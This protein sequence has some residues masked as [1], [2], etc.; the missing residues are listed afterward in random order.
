MKV[1]EVKSEYEEDGKTI[2]RYEHM[3]HFDDDIVALTVAVGESFKGYDYDLI[4][5]RE[6]L[7]IVRNF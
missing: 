2:T 7:T 6:V 1:F 3:T 4:S 5:V